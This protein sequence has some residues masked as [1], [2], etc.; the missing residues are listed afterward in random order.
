VIGQAQLVDARGKPEQRDRAVEVEADQLELAG[1]DPLLVVD[2][3]ADL[4]EVD[5]AERPL[6]RH[7]PR[8]VSRPR[9]QGDLDP[10]AVVLDGQARAERRPR[11][12]AGPAGVVDDAL[13]D[14]VVAATT[15][16]RYGEPAQLDLQAAAELRVVAGAELHAAEEVDGDRVEDQAGVDEVV[17]RLVQP[18]PDPAHDQSRRRHEV[19]PVEPQQV[20][21]H[22]RRLR[23]VDPGGVD[24]EG[25]DRVAAGVEVDAVGGQRGQRD[26]EEADVVGEPDRER[27]DRDRRPRPGHLAGEDEQLPRPAVQRV[28]DQPG[29]VDR[30]RGIEDRSLQQLLDG[31]TLH[32]RLQLGLD[33]V[34]AEHPGADELED[35]VHGG[36]RDPLWAGVL[37]GAATAVLGR[38][39]G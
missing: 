8:P 31:L 32:L 11:R 7:E 28:A 3:Q 26:T 1:A 27:P 12:C 29:G 5:R 25:H 33:L 37:G 10:A 24:L 14:G 39:D 15:T 35:G 13:G 19:A 16:E 18:D 22:A 36:G 2:A 6:D 21:G 34:D 9:G 4:L 17:A 30:R 20:E 23:R 38:D